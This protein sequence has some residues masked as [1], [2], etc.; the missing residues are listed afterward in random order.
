MAKNTAGFDI[1]GHAVHIAVTGRKGIKRVITEQLPEGMIRDGRVVSYEAL[2]DFIRETRKK[3]KIR[4]SA[5]AIILPSNL[6]FCR[7]LSMPIMTH[8]QLMVNIPYEFRDFITAE[9]EEYF[10]DYAVLKTVM[11]EEGAPQELDLM[12]AATLKATIA[13]YRAMFRRAGMK[14][15]IAVPLETAYGNM[16]RATG[17]EHCHCLIDLGHSAVRLYMYN[18]HV[19]ESSHM[20]EYGC[21]ALDNAIAEALHVDPFIAASYREANHDDCQ[22]LPECMQIYQSLAMEIQKSIYFFRYNSPDI[23]LEHIHLIGGGANIQALRD[24]LENTLSVPILDAR[25]ILNVDGIDVEFGLCA[26]GAALQ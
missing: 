17:D 8:E 4:V 9:K 7:R 24:T 15:T 6:C 11:N 26:A 1:G 14:L 20:V 25:E 12:A 22:N 19:F 23:E 13:E 5:A 10:Y 3:H 2:G 16:L 18:G 21:S